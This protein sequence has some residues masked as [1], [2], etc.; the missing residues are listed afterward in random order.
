M[1]YVLAVS[2]VELSWSLQI[3]EQLLLQTLSGSHIC[4]LELEVQNKKV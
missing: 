1:F 2:E 3:R 4:P